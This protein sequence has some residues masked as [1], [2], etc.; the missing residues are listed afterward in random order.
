LHETLFTERKS[1]QKKF[2]RDNVGISSLHYNN[3]TYTEDEAKILNLQFASVFSN[4]D[5]ANPDISR[6]MLDPLLKN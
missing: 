4:D 6:I 5:G 2:F 3:E 1:N